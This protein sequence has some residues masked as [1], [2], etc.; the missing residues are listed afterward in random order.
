MEKEVTSQAATV[1]SSVGK[2]AAT[3][4]PPVEASKMGPSLR[5]RWAQR[6]K[7]PWKPRKTWPGL[8][9]AGLMTAG[10]GTA[11]YYTLVWSA[12]R[13]MR[14]LEQERLE[15]KDKLAKLAESDPTAFS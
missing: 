5:E 12:G 3:S 7:C 15:R 11:G 8:L 10:L 2:T 9:A 4:D 13:H 14:R 6:F 1:I